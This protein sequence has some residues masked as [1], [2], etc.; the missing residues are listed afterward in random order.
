MRLLAADGGNPALVAH[1][2]IAVVA[3]EH[4]LRALGDHAATLVDARVDRRL[5]AALAD[6]LDLR[7][8]V[9]DLEEAR[10]AGEHMGE[11][12]GAQTE[13]EHGDPTLVH[14]RAQLVDLPRREELTLVRDDDVHVA[15]VK[16]RADRPVGRDDAADRLK[17]D[18][19]A[20]DV[21]AV[22]R[23]RRGLDEQDV[24]AALLVIELGDQRL[25]RLG[26][27]H[28]SVFEIQLCHSRFL[29]VR[30]RWYCTN[31]SVFLSIPYLFKKEK[32]KREKSYPPS[33]KSA[34]SYKNALG[35]LDDITPRCSL[36]EERAYGIIKVAENG[37]KA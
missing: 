3:A 37:I 8:A 16:E 30:S 18:T 29:F 13:A 7:D 12:I 6:G 17:S 35:I 27:A 20:D 14:D 21:G 36:T 15:L 23:V 9:R 11:E 32:G 25:R 22:A 19:R 34:I 24:H 4:D 26:G 5:G 10:G 1:R 33:K 2:D 28:R 31:L